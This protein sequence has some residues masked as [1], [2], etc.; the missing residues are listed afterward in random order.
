VHRRS[1]IVH[2]SI[3]ASRT[4]IADAARST[5]HRATAQTQIAHHDVHAHRGTA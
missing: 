4:Q 2:A 5:Q 3:A 1:R